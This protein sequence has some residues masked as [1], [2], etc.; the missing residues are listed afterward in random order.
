MTTTNRVRAG[1]P[2]PCAFTRS[3]CNWPQ[4]ECAGNCMTHRIDASQIKDDRAV[5]VAGE[6]RGYT[7]EQLERDDCVTGNEPIDWASYR[8]LLIAGVIIAM[9]LLVGWRLS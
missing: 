1:Q 9:T 8:P 5:M 4:S 7:P 6:P 2:A 3:G